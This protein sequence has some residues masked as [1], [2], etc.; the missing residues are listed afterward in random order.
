MI[1][2]GDDFAAHIGVI[3]GQHAALQTLAVGP[4]MADPAAD[5][6]AAGGGLVAEKFDEA[7]PRAVTVAIKQGCEGLAERLLRRGADQE[8]EC[9]EEFGLGQG[10]G[11][12]NGEQVLRRAIERE[13]E[14][15]ERPGRADFGAQEQDEAGMAGRQIGARI[16]QP[17]RRAGD[18]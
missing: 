1:E 12:N 18:R 10:G 5:E 11:A 9:G 2:G 4:G 17:E 7:G 14:P 6:P 8:I 3:E 16:K 15:A 13:L